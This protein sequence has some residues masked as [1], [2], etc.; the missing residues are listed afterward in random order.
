LIERAAN[1][2]RDGIVKILFPAAGMAGY[3]VPWLS[4]AATGRE[5]D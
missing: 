3:T 1:G 4:V 2:Y 5:R